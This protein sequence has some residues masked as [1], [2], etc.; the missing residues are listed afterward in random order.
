MF[1]LTTTVGFHGRHFDRWRAPGKRPHRRTAIRPTMTTGEEYGRRSFT[2]KR[3]R[4]C[5]RKT[6]SFKPAVLTQ[7]HFGGHNPEA[8]KLR[9]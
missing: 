2:E 3:G 4:K 5:R 8:P 7:F 1:A 6:P 9:Q